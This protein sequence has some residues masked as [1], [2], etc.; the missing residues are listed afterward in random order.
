MKALEIGSVHQ[1]SSWHGW[2]S[3]WRPPYISHHLFG[4][5]PPLSRMLECRHLQR[6]RKQWSWVTRCYSIKQTK[7]TLSIC[8][9]WLESQ[10]RYG[11]HLFNSKISG[12]L[13]SKGYVAQQLLLNTRKIYRHCE[14]Y[15]NS[16]GTPRQNAMRMSTKFNIR[17]AFYFRSSI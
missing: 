9:I 15:G 11:F 8:N 12:L 17:S 6:K 13:K 4:I 5:L 10:R 3:K 16:R 2:S 14:S 7:R 1:L